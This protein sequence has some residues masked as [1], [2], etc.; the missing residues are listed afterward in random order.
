MRNLFAFIEKHSFL[1]LFL[2]LQIVSFVFI[3]SFNEPQ[4]SQ[5]GVVSNAFRGRLHKI[6]Q[7]VTRYF[8]LEKANQRLVEENARLYADQ[9]FSQKS[10]A[11]FPTKVV[12]P[13]NS[14]QY[15]YFPA[16]VLNNTINKVD[17]YITIDKGWKHGVE[18]NMAVICPS[19]IVGVVVRVSKNFSM[20][21]TVLSPK[22]RVSAKFKNSDFGNKVRCRKA[23]DYF[24]GYKIAILI[25]L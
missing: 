19:G 14:Q 9:E 7:S 24:L 4:K 23:P 13:E 15:E 22:F 21:M 16:R 10:N 1:L 2:L 12:N 25:L 18:K 17:N 5:F 20:V 3:V 6:N 8:Y 11:I